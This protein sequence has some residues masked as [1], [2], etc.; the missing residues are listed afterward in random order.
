MPRKKTQVPSQIDLSLT[1]PELTT[2]KTKRVR[3]KTETTAKPKTK[4]LEKKAKS[5]VKDSE[6]IKNTRKGTRSLHYY[7][8]IFQSKRLPGK[9]ST[10][11]RSIGQLWKWQR[12]AAWSMQES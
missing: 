11:R 8:P 7:R 12:N 5:P 1:A 3:K 4:E 2:T 10:H 9:R 6:L